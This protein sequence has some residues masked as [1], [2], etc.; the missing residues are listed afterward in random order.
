VSGPSS[1]PISRPGRIRTLGPLAALLVPGVLV[2]VAV[3]VLKA[4]PCDGTSCA[5]PYS[6]AWLLV[7]MAFPT[8]LVAGLPW[9]VTP[10]NVLATLVSGIVGWMV[11]GV[12]ASRRATRD[13]DGTWRTFWKE[14]AFLAG[15]VVA[16]VLLGLAAI[17]L[18]LSL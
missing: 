1:G 18:W 17:A 2:G 6:A 16:G 9:I 7:L 5:Q 3:V 15:G 14:L 10:L 12:W 4:W 8:A 13:V 11:F